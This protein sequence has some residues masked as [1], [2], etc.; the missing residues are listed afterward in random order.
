MD[1]ERFDRIAKSLAS[2]ASRRRVVRGLAAGLV[3]LGGAALGPWRAGAQGAPGL[4]DGSGPSTQASDP[5]C[6]GERGISNE[7]CVANR[8]TTNRFCFCAETVNGEKRCVNL[9]EEKCPLRDQCDRNRDCRGGEV[10]VRIGG[11]CG[12]RGRNACVRLCG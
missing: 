8:C 10:C 7:T 4:P 5:T 1:A 9:R 12:F 3:S 2:G 11:C 6:R